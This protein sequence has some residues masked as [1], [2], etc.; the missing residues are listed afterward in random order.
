MP[1]SKTF[2]DDQKLTVLKTLH[3]EMIHPGQTKMYNTIKRYFEFPGMKKIIKKIC[4]NCQE[5]NEEKILIKQYGH[6]KSTTIAQEI[7]EIT[8]IDLKDPINPTHFKTTR[9]TE[10]YICTFVDL[11]S[12][13]TE[14][15]ILWD[16]SSNSI[17]NALNKV[18]TK[19]KKP[20]KILTDQGRQFISSKFKEHL[21]ALNINHFMTSP[22]NPTGNSIVE[23][24]NLV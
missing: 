20:I 8:G 1:T 6:T 11:Y 4:E 12:R 3:H 19:M 17:C 21:K 13:F 7:G 23:R 5:C 2:N 24:I 22:Y 15:E 16:I 14:V 10:F 9:R 18:L